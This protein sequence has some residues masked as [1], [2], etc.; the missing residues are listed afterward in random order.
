MPGS[1]PIAVVGM[2]CRYPEADTVDA[3]FENSLAQR[4]A[5]RRM[6]AGRLS[7]HYFDPEGR[8]ADRAYAD[9]AAV[10][11][12]FSFDRNWFRVPQA[13]YEV[14][15]LT[16]WLALTV[17]KDCIESVRFRKSGA[18]V[19]NDAVRVVVGNTLTGEFSR[20]ALMRLRWPYVRGVVAQQLREDRPDM[21]EA[22]LAAHL[23][24]LEARYKAPFARP[25][26]DMLA[27]GLANTIA[28]RICN[29]FDLK[30]GGFSVDGACSSSLLAVTDACTALVMGD[31]DMVLAGG[32]DLSLDPFELVGFSRTSA[33]A[34]TEMRVYDERSE[35]F[36]PGEGC[37][38]VALMRLEDA[39]E[40]CEDIQ[41][42]ITGWGIS[43]DGRGGLTRPEVDGQRMALA[44]AYR[45]AGYGIDTVGYFEGHGTGTRVGDAAELSALIRERAETGA[46]LRP[47]VISSIKANIGHTKAAAGLAGLLRATQVLRHAV[48]PPTTAC[49]DPHPLF[50]DHADNLRPGE[51]TEDWDPAGQERRAGVSAM[52]FGGINTHV[53]LAEP[54]RRSHTSVPV[55]LPRARLDTAQDCELFLFAA[56]SAWDLA[57][58][59]DHVRRIAPELSRA[60]M[61]DLAVE[62][63]RRAARD[64]HFRWRA[65]VV[66][67][68]PA[69]LAEALDTLRA[70]VEAAGDDAL[71]LDTERQVF[72]S[73]RREPARIGFLFS[74]QAAPARCRGGLHARRFPEVAALYDAADLQS[75]AD[76]SDTD[77]AQP[78]IATAS[79]AGTA[80]LARLGIG[81]DLAIGHS[82]GELAALNWAGCYEAP[83]LIDLARRRGAVMA[84]DQA[85]RGA[86]AAVAADAATT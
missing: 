1:C 63:G 70:Q 30:G 72:L 45:R 9:Q 77:F 59:I 10:L 50:A 62:L 44:R 54:P 46:P 20:A 19:S 17:A 29:H 34:R 5:F 8:A 24:A 4:R 15:D 78:A 53:T 16:H 66:A 52:G 61:G 48:L 21:P 2:A 12:G 49:H 56:T 57:W 3:L 28:G 60:E 55:T 68:K 33:L 80:L 76:R 71:H 41:A 13:S 51:R 73:S 22:E 14:T 11:N 82:L 58:T 75:F 32:V 85:S 42:V 47:A 86:M 83:A 35:G 37:G 7:A 74:G 6:P 18:P 81:G 69:E 43:S 26:E 67:A 38:F 65:A 31:A 36:W 79:A 23:A 64:G 84:A 25:N 39:L 27:G 40:Q